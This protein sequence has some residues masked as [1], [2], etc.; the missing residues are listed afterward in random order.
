MKFTPLH[1]KLMLHYYTSPEPFPQESEGISEYRQHL[2]RMELITVTP[3]CN[4]CCYV[5]T[6][7]GTAFVQLLCETSLPTQAWV[8]PDGTQIK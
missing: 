8:R 4:P 2:I 6:G 5:T 1:L 3:Q 7:R